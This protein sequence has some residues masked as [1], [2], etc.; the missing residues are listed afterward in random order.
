MYILILQEYVHNMDAKETAFYLKNLL[1][2]VCRVH[3]F[4]IIHRDVKPNNFLYDRKNKK[5]VSNSKIFYYKIMINL[6][7]DFYWLILDWH[8]S[9]AQV[10]H[11]RLLHHRMQYYLK[12]ENEKMII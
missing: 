10:R 4:G 5:Y 1:L 6:I 7:S 2:A 8:R 12:N 3:K 11:Q 9:V